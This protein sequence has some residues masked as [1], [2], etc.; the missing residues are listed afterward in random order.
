M[1]KSTRV[2]FG[3]L[4]FFSNY[5]VSA[6]PILK[7]PGKVPIDTSFLLK[8]NGVSQYLEIKGESRT[9]PVL[10]FIH[11][12]PEWPATPM[13][14]KFNEDLSQDFVLVS[15]DQ[16]NC[17]KSGS[18]TNAVLIPDLFVEDAHEVTQYLKKEFNTNKIFIACHSW[19]TIIGIYL[20]Q[21]FPGDYA[22]YIGM[23][24]FVNP[25]KSETLA[26]AFVDQQAKLNHDTATQ[27]ALKAIPFTQEKGYQNGFDGLIAFSMLSNKYFKN[28]EVA[29]LP[30]P[31]HL[32]SD[33]S[34]LDWMTPLM[35]SGRT[36]FNYMNST[37]IDLFQYTDFKLPVYFFIGRYDHI[38]SAEV[39]GEYFGTIK[40]PKKKLYWFEHSGHSPNWE[41]PALFRQRLVEVAAECRD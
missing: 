29:D 5:V 15:W 10:L 13:I 24:Q 27:D 1:I 7:T 19:G 9:N 18:D 4:I 41:E 23:G 38:T 40:A 28:K 14:R 37:N 6:Q 25:N 36:L 30:D 22:A 34:N 3:C 21:K 16:R 17:G 12:G 33:Y 2:L 20:A 35:T 31:T 39:A 26:R 32:Y 8:I 11:G